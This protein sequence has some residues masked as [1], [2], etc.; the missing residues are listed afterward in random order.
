MATETEL[1]LR[2][3]PLEL[4][5]LRRNAL[6]RK[7]TVGRPIRQ[8][9]YSVYF[10][11]PDLALRGLEMALRLRR[12]GR[13]WLQT[14][15]GG[16]A[17][18]AG[19]HSREEWESPLAGEQLDLAALQ[20]SPLGKRLP[21]EIFGKITPVFVTEFTRTVRLL[22]VNGTEIECALDVGEVRAGQAVW[23]ICEL[24]LEL[25]SGSV[26][27]LFEVALQ[28]METLPLT[29][30]NIS[31][32]EHGYE[33]FAPVPR[34]PVKAS[35]PQLSA[36]MAVA[37]ALKLMLQ[38]CLSHW[39][40]NMPGL[41]QGDNPEFLHQV[42]VALR[43][44]RVVLSI[45]DQWKRD[46]D[47]SDLRAAFRT[48]SKAL[49]AARDWDVLV[50]EWL[51]K[52]IAQ[53]PV[54]ANETQMLLEH[55]EKRRKK[56][57][58]DASALLLSAET[59]RLLLKLGAWINRCADRDDEHEPIR[60]FGRKVLKMHY[61]RLNE[62]GACLP[63]GQDVELHS[64][65]IECKKMR[66][67]IELMSKMTNQKAALRTVGALEALQGALGDYNDLIRAQGLLAELGRGKQAAACRTVRTL[68]AALE[69]ESKANLPS[70]WRQWRTE[71]P[72]WQTL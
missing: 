22:Q 54:Q 32:A 36:D 23:P 68:L 50:G 65:R 11:T 31:K 52:L 55:A 72:I 20:F 18:Q 9:V 1:K 56:A 60:A 39:Q 58:V 13:R 46:R 34:M 64:L 59:H 51:P 37:D 10:D 49:G 69:E 40:A 44:L 17:V 3:D 28:L 14:L 19:L 71:K 27:S 70:L 24:E 7:L 53:Y 57:F 61:R 21:P 26:G 43:R 8:Q 48:L 30:E 41:M 25:K 5:R 35:A 67:S 12:V 33:L 63:D 38:S 15:K 2:L 6:L 4:P 16:G 47:L 42:R 66:Y 62:A 45:A 29:L